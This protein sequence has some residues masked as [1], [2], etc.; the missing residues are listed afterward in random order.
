[1]AAASTWRQHLLHKIIPLELFETRRLLGAIVGLI[2]LA[3][4]WRLGRRVGGPLGR[5]GHAASA[6]AVP[7]LLRAHVHEPEGRAVR[8]FDGD[9]DARPGPPGAGISAALAAHHPDRRPRRRPVD[10][11]AHPRRHGPGLCHGRFCA[12]AARGVSQPRPARNGS[13]LRP[14]RLRAAARPG[15]RLSRHGAD[16]AVVDHGAGQSVPCP[17][18]FLALLREAVEGNVRRRAGV[19]AGYAV[20]VSADAV[21]PAAS[22]SAA[23][24]V[25]RRHR[26]HLPVAVAQRCAGPAQDHLP[27][28]D[29]GC[30]L[31]A[32]GGD[33]E[34]PGAL[35]RHPPLHFRHPADGGAGGCCL[36]VGNELAQ[37]QPS[38]MAARRAGAFSPSA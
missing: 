6:G 27:D 38:P 16:L 19:G 15:V 24:P 25:R 1:M 32:G 28:A 22:R 37:A 12:A 36:R 14:C 23:G 3:V 33:G 10:R 26:R 35:Q 21:R 11:F 18:L 13:P 17:D 2:G 7:D 9:P 5:T 34:A 30:D 8:D 20:V 4:T 29:A 31:A